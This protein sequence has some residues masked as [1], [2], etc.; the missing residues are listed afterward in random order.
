MEFIELLLISIA[1]AVD[2]FAISI[3]ITSLSKVKIWKYFSIPIHFALFHV[4]MVFL[5]YK[6]GVFFK[7]I[8]QGLDHWIAFVLLSGVGIRLIYG[9]IKNRKKIVP[10][11]SSEW[12]VLVFSFATSIDALIIGLTFSFASVSLYPSSLIIGT[13]VLVLSISGLIIGR[14]INGFRIKYLDF[15]A[16]IV[17]I[18]LG[19]KILLGHLL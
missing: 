19:L 4:I 7:N 5:G 12:K 15:A 2:C 3:L 14:K 8:I 17:L 13:T 11:L 10:N 1:L 6:I 16:G 18:I 9:S